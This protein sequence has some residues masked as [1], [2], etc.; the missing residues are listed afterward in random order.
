MIDEDR[1]GSCWITLTAGCSFKAMLKQFN[2]AV[3]NKTEQR[4]KSI[5]A[6]LKM[7]SQTDYV[8]EDRNRYE[9]WIYFIALREVIRQ[10]SK[11][12][13]LDNTMR[14]IRRRYQLTDNDSTTKLKRNTHRNRIIKPLRRSCEPKVKKI[15]EVMFE[16]LFLDITENSH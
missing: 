7:Q 9:A 3:P 12:I 8:K 14:K 16:G 2:G 13:K 11:R 4:S 15:F 1:Y 6:T 5:K 10:S